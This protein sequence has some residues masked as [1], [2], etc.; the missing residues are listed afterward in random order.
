MLKI[1]NMTLSKRCDAGASLYNDI[2]NVTEI[3]CTVLAHIPLQGITERLE[4]MPLLLASTMFLSERTLGGGL[5]T[6]AT[7]KRMK[8]SGLQK[9]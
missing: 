8:S 9:A 6:E 5:I 1:I 3:F 7:I 4:N 2:I